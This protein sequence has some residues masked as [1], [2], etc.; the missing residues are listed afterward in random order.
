[1][2][3]W[4]NKIALV[5]GASSGI[6][7]AIA[8]KLVCSGITVVGVARRV[9]NI[10]ELSKKLKH[11]SGKLYAIK[12]DMMVESE[13]LKAFEWTFENLGPISILVNNAGVSKP[14]SFSKSPTSD[15][16]TIF[17]TNVISLCIATREAYKKMLENKIDGHII[18][19]SSIASYSIFSADSGVYSASK[20]AVRA[21]T[22]ALRKDFADEKCKIKITVRFCNK[23]KIN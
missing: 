13:I 17:E 16:R 2:E 11:K 20:F 19:I 22:E 12:V 15:Y 5:T 14:I 3:K 10:E 18:H 21:L 4:V 9:E 1:M 7:A 23:R 8:E 6:G